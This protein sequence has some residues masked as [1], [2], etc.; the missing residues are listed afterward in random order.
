MVY[1]ILGTLTFNTIAKRDAV[2]T[3]LETFLSGKPIWGNT[4]LSKGIDRDTDNPNISIEVRF[5]QRPNLD[6]LFDLAKTELNK[7]TGVT[8]TISIHPCTHDRENP[9]PCVIENSV[10][11]VR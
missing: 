7:L 11:I 10:T 1:A 5:T 9:Q 2:Y 6:N 8:A 4:S 3:K